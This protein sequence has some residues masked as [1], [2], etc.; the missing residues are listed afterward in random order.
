MG[1]T[2]GQTIK[3]ERK[4]GILILSFLITGIGL[5]AIAMLI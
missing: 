1:K 4:E 5:Q 2:I 3:E